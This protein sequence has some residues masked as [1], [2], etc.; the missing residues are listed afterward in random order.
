MTDT[1]RIGFVSTRLAGT[2]GVSLE[3]SKWVTVLERL[4]HTCFYFAGRSDWPAERSRVVPEAFFGHD[5]IDEI[6]HVAFSN[7][8]REQVTQTRGNPDIYAIYTQAV[9]R[10]VRPR[11]VTQRIREL[12][13]L[14]KQHL[15]AFVRDFQ[16]ELLIVEN[17]LTIP[18]NIP[19]GLALT[20]LI[21]ETGLPTIA[22]H[23]DFYWERERFQVNCVADYLNA[24]FPPTLPSIRH[25]V[26][27]SI[28]ARELSLRTGSS[29]MIVPNVMDFDQA[30]P[31]LDDYATEIGAALGVRPGEQFFL[32]P[33]RVVQRK[34]IEYAIE[35][36]RRVGLPAHLVISHATGDEGNAYERRVREYAAL[37]NVPVT[38]EAELIRD[39]RGVTPDGRQIYRLS[40]AYQHADL[41]TYPSSI[42]G[43]GNAF[44][45][46]VY[47]RRPIVVNCYST[48]EVDI[49]PR[50]FRVIEFDGYITAATVTQTQRVLADRALA[51]EMAEQNYSLARRYYSYAVLQ[52]R[53]Q[54][55]L[56]DCF[57]ETQRL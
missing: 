44:L 50:G 31:P 18:M 13:E 26:I 48:F 38:F 39:Q 47:Y 14:L 10:P 43:F 45:E 25:V 19:L 12:C 49:K 55:L 42:E 11:L 24:A 41:V 52:R 28:A 6:M 7:G 1:R 37:M 46:A 9:S 40:D 36:T 27:N 4:G 51:A 22:H 32:Q 33:T 15:Y 56:A 53:L 34:G 35:L 30:P 16:I 29:A 20:E 3:T 8:W 17:A 54:T 2:D 23:H 21:A 5:A 57:G